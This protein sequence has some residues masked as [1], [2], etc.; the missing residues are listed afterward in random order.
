MKRLL[1]F[2]I[3]ALM[4]TAAVSITSGAATSE[5]YGIL[6]FEEEVRGG[7]GI[8]TYNMTRDMNLLQDALRRNGMKSKSQIISIQVGYPLH[9]LRLFGVDRNVPF[10]VHICSFRIE[11]FP[12]IT[13]PHSCLAGGV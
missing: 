9:D 2:V 5:N 6:A 11:S 7:S 10:N 13:D 8:V 3:I 1:S 12:I 4:L